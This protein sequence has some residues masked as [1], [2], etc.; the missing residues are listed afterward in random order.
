VSDTLTSR[1]WVRSWYA[2]DTARISQLKRLTRFS[3]Y[4]PTF[5]VRRNT[6][7]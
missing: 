7:M 2:E 4:F 5:L 3:D 1:G 6:F